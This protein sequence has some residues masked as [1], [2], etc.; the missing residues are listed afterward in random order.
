V[1]RTDDDLRLG[2]VRL[3]STVL[4]SDLRGFTSVAE[5]LEPDQVIDDY[6]TLSR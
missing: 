1:S 5:S 4:F 6:P 2:G 3:T